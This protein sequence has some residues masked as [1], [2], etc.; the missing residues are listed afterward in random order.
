MGNPGALWPAHPWVLSIRL[1][2][3]RTTKAS[4]WASIIVAVCITVSNMF[5]SFFPTPIYAGVAAM[6]AS[7]VLVPVVSLLT[8]KPD[9]ERVE[10]HFKCYD[11]KTET[12]TNP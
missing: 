4:V 11:R 6:L 2:W 1:Y 8:K 10:R 12:E 5:F 3:K 7:L 9:R